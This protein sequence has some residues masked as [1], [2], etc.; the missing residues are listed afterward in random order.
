M[1]KTM[2]LNVRIG[3][4]LSDFVSVN[5]GEEG[6]YDNASEYIRDLI[7]QD[8]AR[9]ENV[10]YQR[11]KAEIKLAFNAPESDYSELCAQ[12]IIDRNAKKH[13]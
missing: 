3:G 5:I 13:D 6:D 10:L 9:K 11:L 8:K 7:R 12:D 2:S 1:Q 4:S